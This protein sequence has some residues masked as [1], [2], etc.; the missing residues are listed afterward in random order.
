MFP[1]HTTSNFSRPAGM[2]STRLSA[3][4][5][6][7]HLYDKSPKSGRKTGCQG[8][9]FRPLVRPLVGSSRLMVVEILMEESH[10]LNFY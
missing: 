2:G 6:T 4:S 9:L 7:P 10:D 1:V 3:I 8:S 5:I